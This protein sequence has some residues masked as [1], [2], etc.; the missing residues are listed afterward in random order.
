MAINR[1]GKIFAPFSLR[2]IGAIIS[3]SGFL[4]LAFK[5]ELKVFGSAIIGIGTIVM[6][7]GDK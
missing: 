1:M 4:L 2:L 3:S 6:A 5:P 7:A